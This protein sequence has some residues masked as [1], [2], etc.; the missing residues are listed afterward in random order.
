[1]GMF[2]HYYES[3]MKEEEV[4]RYD[5]DF[6]KD[7]FL[8]EKIVD[9]KYYKTNTYFVLEDGRMLRLKTYDGIKD[10]QLLEKDHYEVEEIREGAGV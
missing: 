7:V 2:S 9:I 5:G 8:K 6:L 1:M 10:W 4:Y 3:K